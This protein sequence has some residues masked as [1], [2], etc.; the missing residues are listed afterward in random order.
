MRADSLPGQY[1]TFDEELYQ[2][3][4]IYKV[5]GLFT[6]FTDRT[7]QFLRSWQALEK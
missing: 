6:D 3:Y 5:D 4:I 7:V 1:R 2:F